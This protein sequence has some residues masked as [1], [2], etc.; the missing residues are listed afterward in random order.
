MN[1]TINAI[2]ASLRNALEQRFPGEP[3]YID[4]LPQDFQR[5]SF[6]LECQKTELTDACAGL[7]QRT[8]TLLITCFVAVDAYGDSSREALNARQDAV[9]D[10]AGQGF[11]QVGDRAIRVQTGRGRGSPDCAEVQAVFSWFD[12]RPGYEDPE[13]AQTP[14]MEHFAIQVTPGSDAG[15]D[16]SG[17]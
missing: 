9:M 10:I 3:V 8:A 16:T 7:V 1:V 5:P 14:K 12:G 4:E 2:A 17:R 13:T 15:A 11:L 6:T